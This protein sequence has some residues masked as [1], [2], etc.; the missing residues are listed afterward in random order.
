LESRSV[1]WELGHHVLHD[2]G[3]IGSSVHFNAPEFWWGR[4]NSMSKSYMLHRSIASKISAPQHGS[5]FFCQSG[6]KPK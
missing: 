5:G 4:L 2:F 6:K 1:N 3:E